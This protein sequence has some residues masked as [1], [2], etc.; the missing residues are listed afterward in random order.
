[1]LLKFAKDPM[2]LFDALD[3]QMRN[4]LLNCQVVQDA[5]GNFAPQ[6]CGGYVRFTIL[7]PATN[8]LVVKLDYGYKNA[9][10]ETES[11]TYELSVHQLNYIRQKHAALIGHIRNNITDDVK[12]RAEILKR[13][14]R[15]VADMPF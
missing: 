2:L 3:A 8:K 15:Y 11:V 9:E 6:H 13:F 12:E 7:Y 14:S 4:D 10:A 5:N 1:M